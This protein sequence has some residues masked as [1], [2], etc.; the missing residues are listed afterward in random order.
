MQEWVWWSQRCPH[1]PVRPRES[2]PP[3]E[4]ASASS[5]SADDL[6]SPGTRR[7]SAAPPA[8]LP[9]AGPLLVPFPPH[10]SPFQSLV[11]TETLLLPRCDLLPHRTAPHSPAGTRGRRPLQQS[12]CYSY[13]IGAGSKDAEGDRL[14]ILG[15]VIPAPWTGLGGAP[16]GTTSCCCPTADPPPPRS[17]RAGLRSIQLSLP[18]H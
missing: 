9:L 2:P 15:Q 6:T 8:R 5:G 1:T 18:R 16:Q 3:S 13:V 4:D 7:G 11:P 12:G 14:V 17:G 10:G